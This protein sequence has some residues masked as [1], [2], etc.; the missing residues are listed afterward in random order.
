MAVDEQTQIEARKKLMEESR[1][2]VDHERIQDERRHRDL[3]ERQLD[4]WRGHQ[5]DSSTASNWGDGAYIPWKTYPVPLEDRNRIR[6]LFIL[7][8]GLVISFVLV[9]LVGYVLS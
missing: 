1:P 3:V 5:S 8:A 9:F 4:G 2:D 6:M 7:I